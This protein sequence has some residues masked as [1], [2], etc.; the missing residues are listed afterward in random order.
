MKLHLWA[1]TLEVLLEQMK[2][3][4][5]RHHQCPMFPTVSGVRLL[6]GFLHA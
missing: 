2:V 6:L 3:R 1:V 4:G 5:C